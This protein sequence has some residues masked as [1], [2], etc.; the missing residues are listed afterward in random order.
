MGCI[1]W[2]LYKCSSSGRI[3]FEHNTGLPYVRISLCKKVH[4]PVEETSYTEEKVI[5]DLTESSIKNDYILSLK[6]LHMKYSNIPVLPKQFC[7]FAK[8][9]GNYLWPYFKNIGGLYASVNKILEHF[10]SWESIKESDMWAKNGWDE[11]KHNL[12]KEC[13]EWCQK[14]GGFCG[15][16]PY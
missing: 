10:P 5:L 12:F 2:T 13:L 14:Q 1:T 16:W 6:E 15:E 9:D 4:I 8:M 7:Q 11:T 3:N